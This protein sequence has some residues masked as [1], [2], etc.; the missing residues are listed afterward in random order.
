MLA[1][2]KHQQFKKSG[3]DEIKPKRS[4]RQRLDERND[5][6]R[7]NLDEDK[8]EIEDTR[9][10]LPP[11]ISFSPLPQKVSNRPSDLG[12]GTRSLNHLICIPKIY[13]SRSTNFVLEF[14]GRKSLKAQKKNLYQP[15]KR[16]IRILLGFYSFYSFQYHQPPSLNQ[17]AL[18][19]PSFF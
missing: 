4:K 3:S 5:K 8:G 18:K 19:I 11:F 9:Y 2:L 10:I 16:G 14:P 7:N 17:R 6:E 1:L 13:Y 15:S 12:K